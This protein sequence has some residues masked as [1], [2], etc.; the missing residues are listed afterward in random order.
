MQSWLD[1]VVLPVLDLGQLVAGLQ[2]AA[3]QPRE[4]AAAGQQ[5]AL[6]SQQL[7]CHTRVDLVL[8]SVAD[9]LP[10]KPAEVPLWSAL[11]PAVGQELMAAVAVEQPEAHQQT[12][13]D[14]QVTAASCACAYLS[15]AYLSIKCA[16]HPHRRAVDVHGP[17]A[18]LRLGE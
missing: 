12:H 9:L 16:I 4:L 13:P 6:A 15:C 18:Y 14:P 7:V 2:S 5:L 11:Q 1:L 8:R 3:A 10:D 17:A